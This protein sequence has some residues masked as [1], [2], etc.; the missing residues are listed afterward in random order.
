MAGPLK[1][2]PVLVNGRLPKQGLKDPEHFAVDTTEPRYSRRGKPA[3]SY[4]RARS[5]AE[6]TLVEYTDESIVREVDPDIARRNAHL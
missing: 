6:N 3:T 4:W 2:H 1:L 5:V